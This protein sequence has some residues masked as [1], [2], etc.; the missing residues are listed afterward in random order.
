[1]STI[2][3]RL[4]QLLADRRGSFFVEYSS[5][6]LLIAIAAI[7]LFSHLGSAPGSGTP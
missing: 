4:R 1:M 2:L 5:L 3:V 6:A 7:A